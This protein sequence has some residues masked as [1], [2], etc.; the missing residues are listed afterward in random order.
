MYRKILGLIRLLFHLL[1]RS[2]RKK[3]NEIVDALV[4]N[5]DVIK[6][7]TFVMMVGYSKV[8]KTSFI[9]NNER[10]SKFFK[11]STNDIHDLLNNMSFLK[12]DNTIHGKAYWER[13]Y[14]TRIIRKKAL[15]K[16]FSKGFAVVS[17]S[18]NLVRKR[19]SIWLR[20]AKRYSYST[21]II[22][23]I[24]PEKEL[25]SRLKDFDDDLVARGKGVTWVDLY[26]NVQKKTFNPPS[27]YE[28]DDV[29]K[30]ICSS[31]NSNLCY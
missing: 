3:I 31:N 11:L 10:L 20:M 13:Q 23:V 24:C 28:A 18:A 5:Q 4:N 16:A 25:L 22:W 29:R 9:K 21:I 27:P 14:L 15:K 2:N 30:A 19:R 17:D 7:K 1:N 8:G 6:E 26:E 12:D